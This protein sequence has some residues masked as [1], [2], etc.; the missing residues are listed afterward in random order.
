MLSELPEGFTETEPA[1]RAETQLLRSV[2]HAHL[3]EYAVALADL[4]E[5]VR[6]RSRELSRTAAAAIGYAELWAHLD[7]AC[8][9]EEARERIIVRTRR[10]AV[11]Q[12]RWFA[13]DPRVRWMDPIAAVDA[14][15]RHARAPGATRR[16][17]GT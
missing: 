4:D 16:T 11:R 17:P 10:Y 5:A 15:G 8:T 1:E 6:L 9:L 3:G 7:G 14:L 2:A 12:Q 13:A